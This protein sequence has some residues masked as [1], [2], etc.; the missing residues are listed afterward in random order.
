M[1][2]KKPSEIRSNKR[3]CFLRNIIA[4]LLVISMCC[5]M[6]SCKESD[7]GATN[8]SAYLDVDP[9]YNIAAISNV[10]SYSPVIVSHEENVGDVYIRIL[11]SKGQLLG[12]EI[13]VSPGDTVTIGKIPAFSGM[14]TIQGKAVDVAGEYSFAIE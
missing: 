9:F 2:T 8:Y 10:L 13:K 1:D 7:D 14:C 3:R 4:A 12:S 5:I 6:T 11:G